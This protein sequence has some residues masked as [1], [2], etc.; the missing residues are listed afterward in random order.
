VSRTT[1]FSLGDIFLLFEVFP[2]EFDKDLPLP[3]GP[4]VYLDDTPHSILQS[5]KPAAL[6]DFVLPGY[7]LGSGAVACCLR[8][9]VSETRPLEIEP[10][11]LFFMAITALRLKIPLRIQVAGQ[12]EAGESDF[13]MGKNFRLYYLRSA[14]SPNTNSRYNSGDIH[15]ADRIAR[16][17]IEI[18]EN[19]CKRLISAIVL[20]FQANFTNFFQPSYLSL[21]ALSCPT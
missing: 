11:N 13:P 2:F 9:S 19:K 18:L 12:F 17:Y 3:L 8:C 7:H 6:A 4:C 21:F 1:G 20:Y 10:S 16:R 5:A 14:W 15:S